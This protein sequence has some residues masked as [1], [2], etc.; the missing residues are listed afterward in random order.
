[1]EAATKFEPGFESQFIMVAHRTYEIGY[2]GPRLLTERIQG[3]RSE[4][5]NPALPAELVIVQ[6][7]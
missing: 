2:Q 1:M 3:Q 7:P 5:T 4:V 6:T